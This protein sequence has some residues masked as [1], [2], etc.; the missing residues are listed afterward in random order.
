MNFPYKRHISSKIRRV[1]A[2]S[3]LIL[4]EMCRLYGKFTFYLRRVLCKRRLIFSR[5]NGPNV[6]LL[7]LQ[8][9]LEKLLEEVRNISLERQGELPSKCALF[10]CNK[11]DQVPGKEVNEV[12]N[13]VVRKLLRCWPGVEPESQIIHMSTTKASK[14]QGHGY[15]T[16]EFSNLMNGLRLMV[17]KSIGARLEIHWK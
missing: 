4:D 13:H 17:L 7:L 5:I 10:V 12:K 15:I 11:W 9:Q 8:L 2:K 3:R 16:N 1:L 14:A 6:S